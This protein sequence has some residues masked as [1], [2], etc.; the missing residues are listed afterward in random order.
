MMMSTLNK[1]DAIDLIDRLESENRNFREINVELL[2]ALN[3]SV[4]AIDDWL[5]TYAADHCDETH[6]KEAWQR[7]GDS[8]GTIAY[9]AD[10]Q[11]M[12][13][14]TIAKANEGRK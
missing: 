14:Q 6:V 5:N 1:P 9:I 8:G 4:T 11:K 13:R 7:I 10:I 3:A 12:N 2:G